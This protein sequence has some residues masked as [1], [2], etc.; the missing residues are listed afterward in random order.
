MPGTLFLE[1]DNL[2]ANA[3]VDLME[4]S[5]VGPVPARFITRPS[6]VTIA[7]V[8]DAVGI[9]LTIL[10]GERTVVP[11]STLSAGGT[12]GV[13]PNVNE[14]GFSFFAAAGEQLQILLRE[15]AAAATTDIMASVD[16]SPV[17]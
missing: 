4:G 11:R 9:E 7:I 10:V 13:F 6:R 16:I 14:I 17:R 8:A 1:V 2:G 5:L 3:T 15:I 12:L